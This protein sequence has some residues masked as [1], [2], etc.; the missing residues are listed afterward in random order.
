MA[1]Q[2]IIKNDGRNQMGNIFYSSAVLQQKD[3]VSKHIGAGKDCVI[4]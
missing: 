3:Q 1:W 4:V 2:H